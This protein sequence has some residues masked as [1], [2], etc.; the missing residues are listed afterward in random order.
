VNPQVEQVYGT[1][2]SRQLP[3]LPIILSHC[4]Q[5]KVVDPTSKSPFPQE[6]QRSAFFIG[7][8]EYSSII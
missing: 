6:M 3:H 1:L 8:A 5:T 4:G 7:G 2:C